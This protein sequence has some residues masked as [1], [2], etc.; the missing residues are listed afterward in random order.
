MSQTAFA[1]ALPFGELFI[2]LTIVLFAFTTM[3]GW[4]YYGERCAQYLW[5]T[6]FG[7]YGEHYLPFWALSS[8]R[9]Q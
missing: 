4:S 3:L 6:K 7:V 5:G 8:R 9:L 2:T 1:S